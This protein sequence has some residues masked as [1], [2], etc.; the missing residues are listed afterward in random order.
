MLVISTKF[1]AKGVSSDVIF[2]RD[3]MRLEK[4]C[5]WKAVRRFSCH[6]LWDTFP[7]GRVSQHCLSLIWSTLDVSSL[8]AAWDS[9]GSR[10]KCAEKT[11]A[12]PMMVILIASM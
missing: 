12:V 7:S 9:F 6:R 11:K 2:F 4:S 5:S 1:V 3:N 8:L 10:C